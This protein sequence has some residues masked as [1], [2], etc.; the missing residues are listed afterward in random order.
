MTTDLFYLALT[1]LLT[2]LLWVPFIIMR[3]RAEG[4]LTATDYK[5]LPQPELPANVR[6]ANRAH[7]NAVEN[8]PVFVALVLVAHVSGE[9]DSVTAL[10]ATVYFWIRLAHALLF[11][12]GT[13]YARTAAFTIGWIAQLVI[14]YQIVT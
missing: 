13:P 14:F 8:L 10:A 7:L 9:A 3:V 2:A 1:A 11:Y 6:C 4:A 5:E 12:A